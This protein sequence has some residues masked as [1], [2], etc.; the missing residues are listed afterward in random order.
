MPDPE[1]PITQLAAAAVGL[2]ELYV[3]L[4]AA[5]FT[6]SQALHLVGQ[7]LSAAAQGQSG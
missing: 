2:H 6:E 1:D 7:A 5:G 3:S 4:V